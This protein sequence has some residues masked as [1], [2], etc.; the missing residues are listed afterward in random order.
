MQIGTENKLEEFF[1]CWLF[2]GGQHP[3][4]FVVSVVLPLVF[5]NQLGSLLLDE[6]AEG[7]KRT[8]R[9]GHHF[10]KIAG[11]HPL[12]RV[13]NEHELEEGIVGVLEL[14]QRLKP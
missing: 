3:V 4:V 10:I 14:F 9:T 2:F 1:K 13:T 5:F 11:Q 12:H 6:A 8:V 7:R